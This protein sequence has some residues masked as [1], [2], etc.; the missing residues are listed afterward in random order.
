[1]I[2]AGGRS[3][4]AIRKIPWLLIILSIMTRLNQQTKREVKDNR[5]DYTAPYLKFQVK[6]FAS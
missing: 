6:N 2:A 1:M 5:E 4:A 3:L